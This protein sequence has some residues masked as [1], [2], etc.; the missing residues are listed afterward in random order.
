MFRENFEKMCHAR[1]ITPSEACRDI[2]ISPSTFSRYTAESVPR[3]STLLK[4]TDYFG[5]T[6]EDLI[7][8]DPISEADAVA[9][10]LRAQASENAKKDPPADQSREA[11]MRAYLLNLFDR[12]DAAEQQRMLEAAEGI[13]L[14][15]PDLSGKDG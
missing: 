4:M 14:H 7:G 2:G 13:I 6:I 12:A 8:T 15:R 9:A 3:R 5:C 11:I 1:G 10:E